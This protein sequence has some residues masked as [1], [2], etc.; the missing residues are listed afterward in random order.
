MVG[1]DFTLTT[2]LA[3]MTCGLTRSHNHIC[4]RK[5]NTDPCRNGMCA[6]V[7]TQEYSRILLDAKAEQLL[8]ACIKILLC[9]LN[10]QDA[11]TLQ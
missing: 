5:I 1:I 8:T 10:H 6:M 11:H 2:I 4:L 3:A 7:D 9:R